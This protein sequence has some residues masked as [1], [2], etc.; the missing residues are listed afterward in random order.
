MRFLTESR[1]MIY[2]HCVIMIGIEEFKWP[3]VAFGSIIKN[4]NYIITRKDIGQNG[5]KAEAIFVFGL[6]EKR[7]IATSFKPFCSMSFLVEIIPSFLKLRLLVESMDSY[8]GRAK[9]MISDRMIRKV[10]LE[11][12]LSATL[13]NIF[14]CD[15]FILFASLHP[16]V[17]TTFQM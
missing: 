9:R 15:F 17:P 3:I 4:E 11:K 1:T 5:T 8:L 2:V 12:S 6:L 13:W 10:T 16:H 14:G 7:T